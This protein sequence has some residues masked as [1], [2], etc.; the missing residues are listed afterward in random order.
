MWQRHHDEAGT[1]DPKYFG[2]A[3]AQSRFLKFFPNG[4]RSKGFHSQEREYKLAAKG[5]LDDAAPLTEA[6]EGGGFGRAILSVFQ[7]TN[8]VSP[9]EKAWIGDGLRGP[10]ADPF[11]RAAAR[12]AEDGTERALLELRRVLKAHDCA[13][14]TIATYL[15][16]LWRPEVHMFLKPEATKDFAVRV[17]HPFASL[18]KAQLEFEVYENLLDLAVRTSEELFDLAP[19]DWID[20]QSLIW[21]VGDYRE[22]REDVYP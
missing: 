18:Y 9:F 11:V 5:K 15:P 16:F 20:I 7:A 2:Y 17:G 10:D 8:K 21:V 19:S 22:D 4:F 14:W 3:G 12:F 6:L 13:R 1:T